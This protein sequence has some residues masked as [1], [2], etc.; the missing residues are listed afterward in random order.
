MIE[1]KNVRRSVIDWRCSGLPD[2]AALDAIQVGTYLRV[3]L[4]S[5]EFFW[6]ELI[7]RQGKRLMVRSVDRLPCGQVGI[8]DEFSTSTGAVFY[9]L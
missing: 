7:G 3:S 9:A 2:K 8:G 5:G 6:V 4:P 1:C